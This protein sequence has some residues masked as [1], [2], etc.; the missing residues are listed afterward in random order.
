[1]N[2]FVVTLSTRQSMFDFEELVSNLYLI[3]LKCQDMLD[4]Y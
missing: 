1:M 3:Q 2:I 4:K